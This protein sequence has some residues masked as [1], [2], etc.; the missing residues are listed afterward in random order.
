MHKPIYTGLGALGALKRSGFV[1]KK[2]LGTKIGSGFTT[3]KAGFGEK[4]IEY[5]HY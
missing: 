5:G 4:K 1:S 3:S 2:T